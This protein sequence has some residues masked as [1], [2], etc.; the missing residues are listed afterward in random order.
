LIAAE[1]T[2]AKVTI[3][4]IPPIAATG[5]SGSHPAN[6][7]SGLSAASRSTRMDA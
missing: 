7:S 3:A 4:T 2:P 1:Q 5:S 6:H